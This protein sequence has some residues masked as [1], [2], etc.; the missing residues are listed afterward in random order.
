[1]KTI[2][3]DFDTY[4]EEL[5]EEAQSGKDCGVSDVMK[6]VEGSMSLRDFLLASH[7]I[8]DAADLEDALSGWHWV[9]IAKALGRKIQ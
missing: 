1:M 6:F 8:G 9:R 5:A 7:W 4:M 2:T 3:F